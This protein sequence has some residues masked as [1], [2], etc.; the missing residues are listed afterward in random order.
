MSLQ[1]GAA[2]PSHLRRERFLY[3]E[4]GR[5]QRLDLVTYR[6]FRAGNEADF[7]ASISP[8]PPTRAATGVGCILETACSCPDAGRRCVVLGPTSRPVRSRALSSRPVYHACAEPRRHCKLCRDGVPGANRTAWAHHD[9]T[10]PTA[11]RTRPA[12]SGGRDALGQSE[13]LG[14]GE[15]CRS[16]SRRNGGD[17]GA[18]RWRTLR[19]AQCTWS[20]DKP[21]EKKFAASNRSCTRIRT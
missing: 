15:T 20:H 11:H 14:V 3:R 18:S 6:S 13:P 12:G 7:I 4:A 2:A 9:R 5:R 16:T 10:S 17:P 21:H 19:R 8:P 1:G